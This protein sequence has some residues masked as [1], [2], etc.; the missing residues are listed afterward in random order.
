VAV[1]ADDAVVEVDEVDDAAVEIYKLDDKVAVRSISASL[2][3]KNFH[4]RR[5]LAS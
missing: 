1:K 2:R 3:L 5:K 4:A